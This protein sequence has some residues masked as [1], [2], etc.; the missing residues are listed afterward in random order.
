MTLHKPI[1]LA[2]PKVLW[3]ISDRS[4][5]I[6]VMDLYDFYMQCLFT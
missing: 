3:K 4:A 6:A 1:Y 2:K 5:H